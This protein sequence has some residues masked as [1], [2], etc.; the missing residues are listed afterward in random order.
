LSGLLSGVGLFVIGAGITL[1]TGRGL[2]FSGGRQILFGLLAAGITFGI[3]RLV[4]V[5]IGG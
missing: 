2:L 5:N 1:M 3:G 4:G